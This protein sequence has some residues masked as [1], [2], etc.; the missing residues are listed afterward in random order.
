MSTIA[1]PKNDAQQNFSKRERCF[2]RRHLPA[3]VEAFYRYAYDVSHT[4]R[5]GREKGLFFSNARRDAWE[6]SVS[7]N[8]VSSWV[9][10]LEKFGWFERIDSGTRRK[11][12]AAGQMASIRYRVLTHEEWGRRYPNQCRFSP[13]PKSGTGP[14]PTIGTGNDARLSQSTNVACPNLPHSPVPTIGTKVVKAGS[15]K[16]EPSIASSPLAPDQRKAPRKNEQPSESAVEPKS[17]IA[18]QTPSDNSTDSRLLETAIAYV[19]DRLK[20]QPTY[21]PIHVCS[22]T[23]FLRSWAQYRVPGGLT[24]ARASEITRRAIQRFPNARFHFAEHERTAQVV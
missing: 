18:T 17:H 4:G 13:V 8:T 3:A 15:S 7:K 11:R 1:E 20:R 9:R 5:A 12:N 19:A 10:S 22:I 23:T 6:F 16:V 14:V 24:S 2:S 21:K